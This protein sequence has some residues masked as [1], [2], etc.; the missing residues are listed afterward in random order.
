LVRGDFQAVLARTVPGDF[1]YMDP[2]FAVRKRRV[3][4][5]YD[6]ASFSFDDLKRLRLGMEDLTLRGIKFVVSYAESEEADLLSKGFSHTTVTVKRN[7][8]GFTGSRRRSKEVLIFN[9]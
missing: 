4:N 7:I 8:S 6:A 3:F 2:P 1:V 9:S 5:E